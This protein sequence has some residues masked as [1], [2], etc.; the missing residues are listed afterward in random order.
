PA[1]VWARGG[2]KVVEGGAGFPGGLARRQ[3]RRRRA[4]GAALHDSLASGSLD[5]AAAAGL[6]T[7]RPPG[8][9][10]RGGRPVRPGRG[11][12]STGAGMQFGGRGG[13]LVAPRGLAVLFAAAV[14]RCLMVSGA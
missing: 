10:V 8:T 9:D 5:R 11:R 14:V 2:G 6:A 3:R 7:P 4:I 1:S 13:G 12:L